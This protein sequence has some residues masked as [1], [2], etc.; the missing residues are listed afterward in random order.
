VPLE[1]L[2][3]I[4]RDI[5]AWRGGAREHAGKP[6]CAGETH[7]EEVWLMPDLERIATEIVL[8]QAE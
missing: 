7:P 1:E 6:A 5:R 3:E 2:I 4:A 8:T